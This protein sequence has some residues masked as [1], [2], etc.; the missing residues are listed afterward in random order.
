MNRKDIRIFYGH[1]TTI[2]HYDKNETKSRPFYILLKGSKLHG[3][4][5]WGG[6]SEHSTYLEEVGRLDGNVKLNSNLNIELAD[7]KCFYSNSPYEDW[8]GTLEFKGNREYSAEKSIYVWFGWGRE[9]SGDLLLNLRELQQG[10]SL[11]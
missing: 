11:I 2:N 3:D 10:K 8:K 6:G 9:S 1:A 7:V 5:I 4:I